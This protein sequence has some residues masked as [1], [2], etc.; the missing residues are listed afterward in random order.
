[1]VRASAGAVVASQ[2]DFDG[3]V[4]A[5]SPDGTSLYVQQGDIVSALDPATLRPLRSFPVDAGAV[6]KAIA[7]SGR[8]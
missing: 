2:P 6:F 8:W 7:P 5:F 1:M 3:T 4:L